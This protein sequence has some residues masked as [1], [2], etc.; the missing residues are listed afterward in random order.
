MIPALTHLVRQCFELSANNDLTELYA[1]IN[2]LS[3]TSDLS[4]GQQKLCRQFLTLLDRLSHTDNQ[5]TQHNHL[6][7]QL[8]QAASTISNTSP[9]NTSINTN[10][11]QRIYE[12]A[13]ESKY[14]RQEL[15]NLRDALNQH[16]IVCVVSPEGRILFANELLC[17]ISGYPNEELT[18]QDWRILQDGNLQSATSRKMLQTITAGGTWHGAI[19]N[20]TKQG[21]SYWVHATIVPFKTEHN[22]IEKY[23]AVQTDISDS[24]RLIDAINHSEQQYKQLV[25]TIKEVVFTLDLTGTITFLNPA[26]LDVVGYAPGICVGTHFNRY[27]APD[28]QEKLDQG[29]Q[30]LITGQGSPYQEEIAM[31]HTGGALRWVVISASI[32]TNQ[33]GEIQGIAGTMDDIT[34]QRQARID[35]QAQVSLVNTLF[36]STPVPIFLKDIN[37][38]YLR[39][40][41]AFIEYFHHNGCVEDIIGHTIDHLP[42]PVER[43]QTQEVEQ[44]LLASRTTTDYESE[45]QHPVYGHMDVM[46]RKAVLLDEHGE[47]L[48]LAGAVINLTDQKNV[49]R[50]LAL[51]KEAAESANRQK[52]QFLAHMS[53]E[54]RTP[55]NGIIG[56]TKLTLETGL[57]D[58]QREYLNMA[59]TS[60]TSLLDIINDILDL[61]KIEA[62]KITLEEAPFG[63]TTLVNDVLRPLAIKAA[64]KGLELQQYI[65]PAIPDVLLGDA[66]RLKQIIANLLSNAVKFTEQG[67]IRLTASLTHQNTLPTLS[68]AVSDTGIGIPEDKHQMIFDAFQQMDDS[69]TR[70]FG[71][72]GLGLSITQKLCQTMGGSISLQ[73]QPGQGSTFTCLLPVRLPVEQ[74]LRITASEPRTASQPVDTTQDETGFRIL[75]AED[76][77]INQK[78]IQALLHNWGYTFYLAANGQEALDILAKQHVDLI[79]MDC[80][81]PVLDGL[82]ASR[83][84]RNNPCYNTLP[85]CAMTAFVSDDAKRRCQMA[86]MNDYLGKPLSPDALHQL[87][88][89][90]INAAA[91]P[92]RCS[93]PFD[94]SKALQHSNQDIINIIGLSFCK[95]MPLDMQKLDNA[96]QQHDMASCRHILHDFRGLL[97]N[98]SAEPMLD[99]TQAMHAGLTSPTPNWPTLQQHYKQFAEQWRYLKTALEHHITPPAG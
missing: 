17:Q 55:L 92:T 21:K 26:W 33:A 84:I 77:P 52:S 80:Q 1:H 88:E 78:L 7:D 99:M 58:I 69:I 47:P 38:H 86:G 49:Q 41:K 11:P 4:P 37:G 18:G 97:Q 98:F 5:I 81:M 3:T 89:H 87:I 36:E 45:I 8:Q 27:V 34:D 51:A 23:I 75:V 48:G 67:H 32:L 71:G 65:D 9:D 22:V 25:S 40:N 82:E 28:S 20:K 12:L 57:S 31:V 50:A 66:L 16:A 53:H 14:T 56:M 85:I 76:N 96:L 95:Q 54:I 10:L 93:T 2:T 79:L 74:A 19:K 30:R 70:R 60:S 39:V 68:L 72:T 44:R 42:H 24:H 35:L 6:L 73:S 90:Y 13:A 29:L 61:S 64:E 46:I 83:I 63:L 43:E 15:I 91:S 59:L 62:D 94:Y